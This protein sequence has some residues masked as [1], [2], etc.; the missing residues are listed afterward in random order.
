[1]FGGTNENIEEI[2]KLDTKKVA[3]LKL[4]LG[5]STGNML[6]DDQKVLKEIFENTDLL[7]AVHSED[8]KIINKY[9]SLFKS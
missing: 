5:S 6:V 4:F 3:A 8:E 7:I 9:L 1:M 2:K